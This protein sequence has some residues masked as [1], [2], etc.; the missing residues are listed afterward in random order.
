MMMVICFGKGSVDKVA[1][2]KEDKIQN[3]MF[4]LS[5]KGN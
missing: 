3:D 1:Q 2:D 5:E 4:G